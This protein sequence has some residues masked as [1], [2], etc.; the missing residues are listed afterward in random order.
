[1]NLCIIQ[2]YIPVN[3]HFSLLPS[4]GLRV[5]KAAGQ[6]N[7]TRQCASFLGI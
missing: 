2:L 4:K 1:M 6:K 7:V 5:K 3:V